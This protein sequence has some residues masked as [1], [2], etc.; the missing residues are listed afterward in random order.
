MQKMGCLFFIEKNLELDRFSLTSLL[1]FFVVVMSSNIYMYNKRETKAILPQ[2]LSP[3][4][5][6]LK[7]FAVTVFSYMQ[8]RPIHL[9]KRKPTKEESTK[10]TPHSI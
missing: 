6:S 3:F 8:A 2:S 5:G 4:S 10:K 7:S 1:V 9:T